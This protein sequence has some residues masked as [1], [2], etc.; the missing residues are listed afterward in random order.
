MGVPEIPLIIGFSACVLLHV[1]APTDRLLARS[2]TGQRMAFSG[3]A[4]PLGK[5]VGILIMIARWAPTQ[6]IIPF[7]IRS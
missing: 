5:Q 6:R 4:P 1:R 2:G 7:R 3:K